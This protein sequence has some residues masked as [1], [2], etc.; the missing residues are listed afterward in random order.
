LRNKAKRI[1]AETGDERWK[2]PSEKTDKSIAKA[3]GLSLLRPFQLLIFETMVLSLCIFC[4]I[5]LGILYLFFGAFPLVFGNLHGFNLWQTG[6]SFIG[7]AIGMLIAAVGDYTYH[8]IQTKRIAARE[9][10]GIQHKPEPEDRLPTAIVGAFLVTSGLFIFAWTSY[11]H[12]HWIAPIIGSG[13]F[14]AG[15][16]MYRRSI[17]CMHMLTNNMFTELFWS[18]L[19]STRSW[20]MRTLYMPRVSWQPMP[21]CGASLQVS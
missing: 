4:A 21:L 7:I 18:S 12:I 3:I 14:A 10:Q 11:S 20:S 8:R 16:A 5:L 6:L 19:V 9:A 2:A 13:I 15:Y 1:R 17:C